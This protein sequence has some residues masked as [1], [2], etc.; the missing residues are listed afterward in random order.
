MAEDVEALKLDS[1]GQGS[2]KGLCYKK[3]NVDQCNVA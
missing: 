1:C 3:G 2:D